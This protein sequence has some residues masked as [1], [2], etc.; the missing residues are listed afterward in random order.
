[1][2]TN[3]VRVLG[4]TMVVLAAW[5]PASALADERVALDVLPDPGPFSD[6]ELTVGL[7]ALDRATTGSGPSL[8]GQ[9]YDQAVGLIGEVAARV[10][11]GRGDQFHNGLELRVGTSS[12]AAFDYRQR[13]AFR[14]TVIDL[15]YAFRTL[16][17]CISSEH[18]Q[19]RLT[20]LLGLSG[21]VANA[22][23]GR[24]SPEN[25]PGWQDRV[26]AADALDHGGLGFNF[27]V[28]LDAHFGPLITGI[29]T[30]VRPYFG[31]GGSQVERGLHME[32]V[33]RVGVDLDLRRDDPRW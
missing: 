16:L 6:V 21:V 17:P 3:R 19:L 11:L 31:L 23:T 28:G 24:G 13:R 27:A 10:Y 30:R 4:W 33:L 18:R 29:T 7:G 5:A 20:G 15:D 25:G 9:G 1:M 26:E 2:R 22:G 12:G 32:A 8:A 14:T